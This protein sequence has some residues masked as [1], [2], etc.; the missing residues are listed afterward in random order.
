MLVSLCHSG[1]N[2]LCDNYNIIAYNLFLVQ[3]ISESHV[4]AI[5]MDTDWIELAQDI[6]QWRDMV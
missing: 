6:N 4:Q 5:G 3:H 2:P 1:C